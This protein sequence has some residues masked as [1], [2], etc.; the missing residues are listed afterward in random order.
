MERKEN[1][2]EYELRRIL[3]VDNDESINLNS[4]DF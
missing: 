4:K 2:T 1:A 3:G